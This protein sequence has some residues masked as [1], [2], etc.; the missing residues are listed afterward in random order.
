MNQHTSHLK[1]TNKQVWRYMPRVGYVPTT[2][3]GYQVNDHF[4]VYHDT[5]KNSISYN[6]WCIVHSSGFGLGYA[7]KLADAVLMSYAYLPADTNHV[8]MDCSHVTWPTPRWH[9][10][11]AKQNTR[12]TWQDLHQTPYFVAV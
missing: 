1:R 11:T 3:S 9:D 7:R 6:L 4:F 2:V 5:Q 12:E 10:D 8:H